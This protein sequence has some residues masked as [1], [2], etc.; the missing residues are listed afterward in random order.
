MTSLWDTFMPLIKRVSTPEMLEDLAF[1]RAHDRELYFNG[2]VS[3]AAMITVV[4]IMFFAASM[5]FLYYGQV[6]TGLI[7]LGITFC[8]GT[9]F[10]QIKL[11]LHVRKDAIEIKEM[12]EKQSK[13]PE[14]RSLLDNFFSR[15]YP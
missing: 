4:E 12:L 9:G 3:I 14:T 1:Y 7:L 8:I 5:L 2:L 15:R 6:V 13:P 11:Y 10:A